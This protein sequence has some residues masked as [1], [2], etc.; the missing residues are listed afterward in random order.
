M[1]EKTETTS[2]LKS[3]TQ[4][5]LSVFNTLK[6]MFGD[7]FLNAVNNHTN[8]AKENI[9]RIETALDKN[10]ATELEHAAHS[11]KGASAQFGATVLS[12]FA[13][14]MEQ[15]GKEEEIEKAKELLDELKVARNDAEELM[16][17][18]LK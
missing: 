1:I 4:L 18:E 14:R 16:M 3:S 12:E 8:S 5:N 10:D 6:N 7:A 13:T 9:Q 2:D 15:C 11:L 17:Q